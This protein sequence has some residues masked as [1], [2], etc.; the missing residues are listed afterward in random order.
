MMCFQF[1]NN[2]TVA[3]FEQL[4]AM[5]PEPV[6]K[7]INVFSKYVAVAQKKRVECSSGVCIEIQL[8]LPVVLIDLANYAS[9]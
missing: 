1:C 6:V 8:F 7:H 4:Q 5:L 2:T 3:T 9:L